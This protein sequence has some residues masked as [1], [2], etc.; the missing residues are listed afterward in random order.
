MPRRRKSSFFDDL[1]DLVA[2][3]PWWVGVAL[4][5]VGYLLLH[6]VAVSPPAPLAPGAIGPSLIW[7]TWLKALAMAGQY[8]VPMVCLLGA[9]LSF[10][11]RRKRESL[12]QEV[13]QSSA[14][15]ALERMS[16]RD[17]EV[18]VGEGFRQRG[19]A[20]QES[21][22][23]GADGGVDLV[24]RKDGETFL[25]Q[26]KQWKALKVGVTVVRELYGVMAARGA[27]GGFVVSS[28]RFT[29]EA[30]AFA[31]GRNIQLL[32]G[33]AL[34]QLI[35]S[36]RPTAGASTAPVRAASAPSAAQATASP[37]AAAAASAAAVPT[38]PV[39][40]QAMVRRV[41][42]RG[43]SAGRAF[44]GCSAYPACKGTRPL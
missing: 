36:G 41:A 24:L 1:V 17:F 32:T 3:M 21:G 20:V 6:S 22:G 40:S 10:L 37:A 35:R 23:G 11:R 16:W 31:Q 12:H 8:I 43:A 28:G 34:L 19:Y 25:V 9:L 33:P 5:P 14:A 39:C 27:A 4:A 38:C 18:L 30:Q 29:D 26:C 13:R 44:W 2:L 15:D 42:K 7:G